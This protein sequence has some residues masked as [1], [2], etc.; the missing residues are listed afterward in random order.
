MCTT[1]KVQPALSYPRG[2]EHRERNTSLTSSATQASWLV[3]VCLERQIRFTVNIS[4]TTLRH[5]SVPSFPVPLPKPL[6][7]SKV[8]KKRPLKYLLVQNIRIGHTSNWNIL[9]VRTKCHPSTKVRSFRSVL[10]SGHMPQG[11][12]A[13]SHWTIAVASDYHPSGSLLSPPHCSQNLLVQFKPEPVTPCFKTF[14]QRAS[15][16]Q[17]QVQ[18]PC[19]DRQ[20]LSSSSPTCHLPPAHLPFCPALVRYS[21]F[22][23]VNKLINELVWS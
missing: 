12:V 2:Y 13:T 5:R 10:G 14:V 7:V 15:R 23:G 8:K 17:N 21:V 3:V 4:K 6:M 9:E 16:L 18:A 11:E 22:I 20:G 1:S 19:H